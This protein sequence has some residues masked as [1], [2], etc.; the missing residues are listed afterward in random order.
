VGRVGRWISAGGASGDQGSVRVQV[1]G[2]EDSSPA[3]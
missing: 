1:C 2:G 3:A